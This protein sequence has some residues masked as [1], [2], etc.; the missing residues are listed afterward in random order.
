MSWLAR[1]PGL[2]RVFGV[3]TTSVRA[4]WSRDRAPLRGLR[5]LGTRL[6]R[7]GILVVR[8]I[9]AHRLALLAAALTFFTVFSI[10]PTLVVALWA[11]KV[12]DHLPVIT[13]QLPGSAQIPSGNQLLHAALAEILDAVYRASE[14]TGL[15]GLGALLYV[16][17]KMFSFTERAMHIIAGSAART[18]RFSRMLGYVALLLMP[19]ALLGLGGLL[20]AVS[21]KPIGYQVSRLLGAIPGLDLAIGTAV[22]LGVLWL[23]ATIFYASAVRA[24]IPYR[25]AAVGGL[26]AA[27][28]LPV[29]FWVYMNFQVGV[30]QAS[31]LGSGFLA[32]PVFLLWAF[33]SWYVLLI[34]AEIA[35]AHHV[36]AVLVHGA[37]AFRLDHTGE[38][39]ASA[40]IMI[41]IS[42]AARPGLGHGAAVSEDDL[43]R[44]LRL[45]PNVVGDLCL[46]LVDRGLLIEERE[47]F[48]LARDPDETALAEVIDAVERDPALDAGN[49]AA[50]AELAPEA[51]AALSSVS[52]T[53]EAA[54]GGPTLGELA[55]EKPKAGG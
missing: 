30:A 47:G 44:D 14:V 25:S 22:G 49:R 21:K 51:R 9:V 15:V 5:A 11:L 40:A 36:D 27:V 23:A 43:A 10:V 54:G 18:P 24:R 38:R 26:C 17:T 45:P 50:E 34:G 52:P 28:A 2:S 16:V 35:V 32:F 12:L 37:R 41:R 13:P 48:S 7:I 31:V 29:V 1:I 33:S 42:R 55:R 46:R 3:V 4:V 6:L 39:Q 19:L 8:G 53:P 20:L